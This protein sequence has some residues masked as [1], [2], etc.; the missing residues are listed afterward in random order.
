[1]RNVISDTNAVRQALEHVLV[2]FGSDR[3]GTAELAFDLSEFYGACRVFLGKIEQL[4]DRQADQSVLEIELTKLEANLE[5]AQLHLR[6]S[7]GSL[8]TF[9]RKLSGL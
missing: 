3:K 8:R 9:N 5:D 7:L 1:M 2:K 4:R 6:D